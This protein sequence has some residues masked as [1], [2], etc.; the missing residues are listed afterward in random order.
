MKRHQAMGKHQRNAGFT[1]IELMVGLGL[2]L[3]TVGII[4]QVVMVSEGQKRSTTNGTDAQISGALAL[5]AVQHEVQ[6]SGYGVSSNP[7][8]IGCTVKYKSGTITGNFNLVPVAIDDDGHGS[9]MITVLRSAKTTFSTPIKVTAD[10]SQTATYFTVSSTVG[11]SNGDLMVAVPKNIASSNCTVVQ[12]N[13]DPA[14]KSMT[15][16]ILPHAAAASTPWNPSDWTAI[17]P[18]AGYVRDDSYLVNLGSMIMNKFSVNNDTHTLQ[19]SSMSRG[20]PSWSTPVDVQ[21]QVVVMKALYGKDTNADG[22]IDVYDKVV[23]TDWTQ[24]KSIRVLVVAR[25]AQFEK[26]SVTTD[27][28]DASGNLQWNVGSSAVPVAGATVCNTSSQCLAVSLTFLGADW[29][30]YRYKIY[31]TVIPLRNVMWNS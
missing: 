25:S 2:G 16:T 24:V 7:A 10:H 9:D 17:M 30:H 28:I 13:D 11:V 6:M 21:P 26:E 31:D 3:L 8:A 14:T 15:N 22:V 27:T 4:A 19:V 23:P 1:L 20:G 18:A 5:Y 12:V 29:N